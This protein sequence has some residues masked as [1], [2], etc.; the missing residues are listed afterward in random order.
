MLDGFP[1]GRA[2][3]STERKANLEEQVVCKDVKKCTCDIGVMFYLV[4][5]GLDV[6]G[7]DDDVVSGVQNP[8]VVRPDEDFLADA[9]ELALEFRTAWGGGH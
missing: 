3:V 8:G 5:A 9:A 4:E 2:E 1:V 6:I 7:M